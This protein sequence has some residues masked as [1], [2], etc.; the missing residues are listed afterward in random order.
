MPVAEQ[1]VGIAPAEVDIAVFGS[2]VAIVVDL[3]RGAEGIVFRDL[4][5]E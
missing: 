2:L 3:Q 4:P 1:Q 5:G